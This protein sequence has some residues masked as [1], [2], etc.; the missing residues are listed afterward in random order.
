MGVLY[1]CFGLADLWVGFFGRVCLIIVFDFGV[2]LKFGLF[3]CL[4][5]LFWWWYCLLACGVGLYASLLQ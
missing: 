2:L 5:M 1:A 3:L 4:T